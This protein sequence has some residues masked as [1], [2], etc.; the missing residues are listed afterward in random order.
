LILEDI[1]D[2]ILRIY[3]L[4]N[5]N[6]VF[7]QMELKAIKKN[8]FYLFKNQIKDYMSSMGLTELYNYSFIND[9]DK[10]ILPAD[11]QEKTIPLLNALSNNLKYLNPTSVVSLLK[12]VETNLSYFDKA[13]FFDVKK[14]F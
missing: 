9:F 12:N 8:E 2:D 7:P 6:L 5:L 4:N 1:V 14:N 11:L 13:R 3:G 10:N